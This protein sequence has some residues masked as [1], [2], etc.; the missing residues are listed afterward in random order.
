[1][2]D[3]CIIHGLAFMAP[4]VLVADDA[5]SLRVNIIK[6]Y[7]H[8]NLNLS[9]IIANYRISGARRIIENNFGIMASRFRVFRRLILAK[10]NA[11]EAI[12]KA[13]VVLHNYLIRDGISDK[14]K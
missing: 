7:S 13:S 5:F 10:V 2:P 14:K 11:V 8:E 6:S 3:P 4:Y 12:I 1:M 9:E